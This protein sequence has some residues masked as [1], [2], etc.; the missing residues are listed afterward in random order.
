[1]VLH[2]SLDNIQHTWIENNDELD[3]I[4]I[5]AP[6]VLNLRAQCENHPYAEEFTKEHNAAFTYGTYVL[7]GDVNANFKYDMGFIGE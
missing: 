7:E 2:V 5:K 6:R 4:N 3:R 1:M